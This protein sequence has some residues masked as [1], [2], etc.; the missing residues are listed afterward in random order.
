MLELK[1]VRDLFETILQDVDYN[2]LYSSKMADKE[3]NSIGI[4]NSKTAPNY[5]SSIGADTSYSIKPITILIHGTKS[6]VAT[7]VLA[8]DVYLAIKEANLEG[9]SI[10]RLDLVYETPVDVG[11][12]DSGVYEYTIN[13]NIYYERS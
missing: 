6:P 5:L 12:D 13:L 2:V 1:E 10:Q 4:Y 11:T 7:E 8:N 9:T 3:N